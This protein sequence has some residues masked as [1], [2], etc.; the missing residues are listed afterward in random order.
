[1]TTRR[2]PVY[3]SPSGIA[4]Y[5]K[6]PE[7]Y[8][9]RYIAANPSVRESQTQPMAIGS[10]FDAYAKS[11]LH[12]ALFG[13]NNDPK[14]VFDNLF[15]AQVESQWRDWA[16]LHGLY[17]FEE[18]KKS[19][20]LADLLVELQ[21]AVNVPKFEID[22]SGV[23]SNPHN[24]DNSSNTSYQR[25]PSSIEKSG[26]TFLG[27]P[28]VFFINKH[29][30]HVILDWKVNG[31]LSKMPKSPMAGYVHLRGNTKKTGSHPDA[32]LVMH[33]GVLINTTLTLDQVDIDWATQLSVYAWL[34]GQEI[35]GD[36]IA[37][38]D[39]ICCAPSGNEFPE[40]RIA[41]HRMRIS[42]DFQFSTFK[43]AQ[44]I[45]HRTHGEPLHYFREMTIE[46]S[47]VRCNMLDTQ[48]MDLA[49]MDSEFLD[50]T[51]KKK[52]WR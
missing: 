5:R 15:C 46:E 2:V 7:D 36:F 45:W 52:R 49:N 35:G 34:A 18:Y 30:A 41:E 21:Q 4:A 38:I 42:S 50:M 51:S 10:A 29:A 9:L 6:D 20:A 47:E 16:L 28:D 8:Y 40:L 24:T 19:G 37:A 43:L 32:R 1:M 23:I 48:V 3:L 17:V 33:N 22:I 26:V 44:D 39:Q 31:Y 25:E 12:E 13:K 27:K 14:Y 11:Y